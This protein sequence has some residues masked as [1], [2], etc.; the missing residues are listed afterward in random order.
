MAP[1]VSY[2]QL[3][4]MLSASALPLKICMYNFDRNTSYLTLHTL[5]KRANPNQIMTYKHA[6]LLLKIY[7]ND[8]NSPEWLDLFFFLR[9]PSPLDGS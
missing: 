1:F 2:P 3:K 4:K 9:L 7:N 5:L 8:N 6:L